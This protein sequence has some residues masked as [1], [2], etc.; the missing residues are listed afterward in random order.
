VPTRH[1]RARW[2]LALALAALCAAAP[3]RAADDALAAERAPARQAADGSWL[4]VEAP[5]AAQSTTRLGFTEVRGQAARRGLRPQDFVIVI[6]VSDSSL[7]PSGWDVDGDGPHGRT[8]P[9]LLARLAAQPELPPGLLEQLR[10]GDFDD[11]VLAA[12]LAAADALIERLDLGRYRV[13]LVAFSDEAKLLAPLGSTRGR[14]AAAL[15][16]LRGDFPRYLRGTNF[17]DAIATAQLALT[18][19]AGAGRSPVAPGASP[20]ERERSILFLSDGEPTLP[21]HG[22][23]ARQHALWAANA[24]AAAGIRLHA[25]ELGGEMKRGPDVFAAMAR[26]TGGHFERL[27]RAGDAI[28]RLRRTDLVGLSELRVTNA[29]TGQPARALRTFPDGSFDGFVE[30]APGRNHVQ[31]EAATSDGSR[32]AAERWIDYDASPPHDLEEARAQRG[33]AEALLDELRRRTLETQVWADMERERRARK[34]QMEIH[35]EAGASP[36]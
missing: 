33:E 18:P 7:R 1:R 11:S 22:D 26:A 14:L 21:P 19:E 15:E 4:R 3:A 12:E 25:F 32:A 20:G 24:A 17:G 27:A 36:E 29:T 13:A 8:G 23:A 16:A 9:A 28:A 34:L 2:S 5:A 30:L 35:P 10:E 31:L 6:D